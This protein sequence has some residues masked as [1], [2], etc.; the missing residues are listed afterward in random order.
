MKSKATI[1]Q[2]SEISLRYEQRVKLEDSPTIHTSRDAWQVFYDHWT[3]DL[4]LLECFNVLFLNR[5]NKV[6][7]MFQ[8]SRG[9]VAGTVVDAK[10]IYGAA[11]KAMASSI[12][13][14]HNHP[15]GNL[16][17]SHADEVLTTKLK[18]AGKALDIQFLDHLILTPDGRYTSFADEGKL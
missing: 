10:I 16:R 18:N 3:D 1:W 12:I 2:V 13:V 6:K 17:P 9:G 5:A 7:G 14:A 4:E 15:S 11:V 8:A